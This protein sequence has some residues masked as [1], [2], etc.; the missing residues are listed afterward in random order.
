MSHEIIINNIKI[1]HLEPVKNKFKNKNNKLSARGYFKDIKIKVYETFDKNQGELRAF[2]S[3]N[4]YLKSYFP[5]LIAYNNKYII[6]EWID[7][8]TLKEA[9]KKNLKN[10]PQSNQIKELVKF[11]WSIDYEKM[12]F[13]YIDYIYKRVN[14]KNNLDLSKIPIRIN[15]NDLSLDNI[16]ITQNGLKIIDNEFLGCNS[17]WILN[18]KNS[19][20]N[21]DFEYQEFISEKLL[22]EL[23]KVRKQW[24]KI[25]NKNKS[26]NKYSFSEIINAIVTNFKK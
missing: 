12:V 15:H 1:E 13:D 19:F 21:E 18:I 16:L 8:K 20:I 11:M 24:T 25:S 14:K 22:N 17:G 6:E 26:N 23:W 3:N 7:G 4:E 5:N 9:N 2:V 10:I